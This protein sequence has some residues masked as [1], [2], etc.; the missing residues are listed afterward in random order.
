MHGKSRWHSKRIAAGS[1]MAGKRGIKILAEMFT[2]TKDV[3][4]VWTKDSDR[5]AIGRLFFS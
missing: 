3:W 5:Q 4:S 2:G 1:I